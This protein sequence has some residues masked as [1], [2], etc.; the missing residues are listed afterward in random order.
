MIG[1]AHS[2]ADQSMR[3]LML[4]NQA[5][6]ALLVITGSI[7]L[8]FAALF[9]ENT[10]ILRWSAG[11]MFALV[12]GLLLNARGFFDFSQFL[13]SSGLSLILLSM[14]IHSKMNQPWLIH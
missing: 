8:L 4:A 3:G 7:L 13:L 2:G 10:V 1:I 11:L 12:F 5:T 9:P 14:T 6:F